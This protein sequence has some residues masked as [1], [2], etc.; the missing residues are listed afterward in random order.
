MREHGREKREQ[1]NGD[2]GLQLTQVTTCPKIDDRHGEPEEGDDAQSCQGQVAQV[3]IARIQDI[4]PH[5]VEQSGFGLAALEEIFGGQPASG[6]IRSQRRKYASQ[7][8][9]L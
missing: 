8:R 1:E 6:K 3:M 2:Y 7:R 4:G 9:M 5:V